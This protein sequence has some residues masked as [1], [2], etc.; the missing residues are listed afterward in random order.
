MSPEMM[1]ERQILYERLVTRM[2][3]LKVHF[4]DAGRWCDFIDPS[5]G[6]P[7]HTDSNTTLFEC[8]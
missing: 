8:D 7:F 5:T 1:D 3:R 4:D 6:K 2:G